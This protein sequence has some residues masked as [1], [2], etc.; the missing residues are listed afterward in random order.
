MPFCVTLL[1]RMCMLNAACQTVNKQYC[2]MSVCDSVCLL[3]VCLSLCV[4]MHLCFSM[5]ERELERDRDKASISLLPWSLAK[6][7]MK[8]FGYDG[9]AHSSP[10]QSQSHQNWSYTS[11]RVCISQ[12]VQLKR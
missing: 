8:G 9:A 2:L 6:S 10:Y 7:Q 3:W 4:C 11:Y 1:A 12:C 5:R